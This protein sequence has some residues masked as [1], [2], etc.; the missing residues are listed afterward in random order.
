MCNKTLEGQRPEPDLMH[1]QDNAFITLK[2]IHVLELHSTVTV[3]VK[4]DI[5]LETVVQETDQ[6][7]TGN[8]DNDAR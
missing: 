8:L 7:L 6:D 5:T 3:V 4:L 2:M 1:K